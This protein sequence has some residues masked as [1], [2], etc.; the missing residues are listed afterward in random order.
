VKTIIAFRDF[1]VLFFTIAGTG[2]LKN[3]FKMYLL[4]NFF[5][6]FCFFNFVSLI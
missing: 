6:K 1:F 4:L 2:G 3:S 5:F